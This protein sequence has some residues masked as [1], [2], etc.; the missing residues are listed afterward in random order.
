[1]ISGISGISGITY[2]PSD[3]SQPNNFLHFF[4][5][6]IESGYDPS[7]ARKWATKKIKEEKDKKDKKRKVEDPNKSNQPKQS[8]DRRV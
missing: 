6:A 1:M 4:N 2:N 5:Q 7:E 8:I 3:F